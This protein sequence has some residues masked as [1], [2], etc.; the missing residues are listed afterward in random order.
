MQQTHEPHNSH[1]LHYD[2]APS[3]ARP[4][5]IKVE[6]SNLESPSSLLSPPSSPSLPRTERTSHLSSSLCRRRSIT[7]LTSCKR[8]RPYPPL[9]RDNRNRTEDSPKMATTP[10]YG[11]WSQQSR[12]GNNRPVQSLERRTSDNEYSIQTSYS[13]FPPVSSR[14]TFCAGNTHTND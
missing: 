11:P 7:S 5:D 12:T 14:N 1:W 3:S 6:S 4:I 2:Y 13:A 9:L 10:A 8:A